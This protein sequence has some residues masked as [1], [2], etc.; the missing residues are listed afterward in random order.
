GKDYEVWEDGIDK[1]VGERWVKGEYFVGIGWR[2]EFEVG[3]CLRG[4]RMES[5]EMGYYG[6]G[7]GGGDVIGYVGKGRK[8]D[9]DKDREG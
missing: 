7:E 9:V 2:E 4:V 3:R 6:V 5:K 8:E 1:G